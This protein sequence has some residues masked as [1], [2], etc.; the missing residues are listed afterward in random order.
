VRSIRTYPTTGDTAAMRAR[1]IIQVA[2]LLA[3]AAAAAGL[4][5][6]IRPT[7]DPVAQRAIVRIGETRL[8]IPPDYM[9]FKPD[10]AGGTVAR[11]E[12]AAAAK[13]FRPAPP[14]R[15]D[16]HDGDPLAATVFITIERPDP[17]LEPADRMSR[18]YVRFL[19]EF[20]WSHPGGL[21]MRRFSNDSPYTGED[22]YFAPP[23]GRQFTARCRRPPQPPDG[24]PS[25]CLAEF[26]ADG[27]DVRLRFSP[28]LLPEWE[29][30]MSGARG[31]IRSFREH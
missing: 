21:R 28:D 11:I 24:L 5:M 31:L 4:A 16:L 25:A 23:E 18:L 13:D 7:A 29:R 27:V 20:S 19:D 15:L 12:L 22:L 17:R 14:P 2:A 6:A 10:R 9:R 8:A 26:R 3:G 30:L 1:A